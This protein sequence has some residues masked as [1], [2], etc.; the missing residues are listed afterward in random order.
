MTQI[1]TEIKKASAFGGP[2]ISPLFANDF[3]NDV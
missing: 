2:W 1:R 3:S